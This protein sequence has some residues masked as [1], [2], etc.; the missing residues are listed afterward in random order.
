MENRPIHFTEMMRV[1][2]L[3]FQHRQTVT[4]KAWSIADH[5]EIIE[6]RNWYVH[7]EYWRGGFIRLRNPINGQIRTVPDIFIFEL[8]GRR[9]F[10]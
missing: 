1:L 6:Y 2:S 4:V 9:V 8:N 5:G 10:L 3:A 7:G